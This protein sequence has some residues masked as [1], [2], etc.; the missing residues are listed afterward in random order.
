[1]ESNYEETFSWKNSKFNL[2]I[3]PLAGSFRLE[4]SKED[5][6]YLFVK[7]ITYEQLT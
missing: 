2:K 1:M 6:L 4:L 5:E 7:N 3:I